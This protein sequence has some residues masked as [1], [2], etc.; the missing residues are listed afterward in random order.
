[1]KTDQKCWVWP[2]TV[3]QCS[4]SKGLSSV[5][6]IVKESLVLEIPEKL[7]IST[8]VIDSSE[9]SK[10]VRFR[11]ILPSSFIVEFSSFLRSHSRL[12]EFS[13]IYFSILQIES[14]PAAVC[15]ISDGV[16]VLLFLLQ[17]K[18]KGVKSFWYPYIDLLPSVFSPVSFDEIQLE[19][20]SPR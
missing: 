10:V 16:K 9:L 20:S 14:I 5:L 11:A 6:D 15:E 13:P 2:E 12:R 7:L 17:E 4:E 18:Y 8:D 3:L 1:M 19:V